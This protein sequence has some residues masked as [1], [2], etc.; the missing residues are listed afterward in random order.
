MPLLLLLSLPF[1]VALLLTILPLRGRVLP[2][3]LAA[4]APLLGLSLLLL[5]WPALVN[6]ETLQLHLP[7]LPAAG[8]HFDLRLDGL[9]A[10]FVLLVYGIGLL[11]VLYGRYYL[12]HE[13]DTRRFFASLLLFM[14]AMLGVAL[15]DNLL[16][17]LTFWELTSISSFLLIG[18]WGQRQDS[19]QGA[20]MAL[21]VTGGG[22]LCLLAGFLLLG[23][24]AGSFAIPEVI[25]ARELVQAD[26]RYPALLC[27]ILL[28]AF[29]KSA[30]FP[31]H[32]WLP[33]A[34]AA[35]TPVS[36][37]LHSATMVKAGV[38]LLA[39]LFP[40][41]AGTDLWF[42]MVVPV[43]LATLLVGAWQ[44]NLQ[45]DL[46]GLLAY[47]TISHLGL[48]TLLF[49]IG[50]PAAAVAA[51]FHLI[52]HATFKAGLFMTAGIVDHETGTRDLSKLGGLARLMP[53]TALL[54]CVAAAAMAGVPLLNGFLSKEM[55][56]GQ[57]LASAPLGVIWLLPLLAWLG[58]ALSVAYSLRF[59]HGVFFGRTSGELPLT[60]HEAPRW[61]R[62]PIE[63]LVLLCLAVG[64]FPGW[65]VLELLQVASRSVVGTELP[66]IDLALWHGV[67]LPL[68]MSL[69]AMLLGLALYR[70]P[71]KLAWPMGRLVPQ[72]GGKRLFDTLLALLLSLSRVIS[73]RWHGDNLRRGLL[74]WLL[75]CL[76]AG[77]WPWWQSSAV[78]SWSIM[79]F[80]RGDSALLAGAVMMAGAALACVY[81]HTQRVL[82]VIAAGVVG[83]M[84]ALAFVLYSSPDLALTQLVVEV[85]ATIL[86]LLALRH[87]PAP[88]HGLR[89]SRGRRWRDALLALLAGGG[90]S[91]LLYF[92]LTHPVDSLSAY[93]LQHSLPLGGGSNVVNVILV[94]FRGFDTFGEITV[95]GLAGLL[96]IKLLQD[97]SGSRGEAPT[98]PMLQLGVRLLLPF[99][100]L[101]AAYLFLRGHQQPGGGFVAGLVT[102]VALVL[103]VLAGMRLNRLSPPRWMALGLTLA[104]LTGCGAWWFDS[105]FLSSAHGH[106]QLPLLGELE[107]ATAALFDLAVYILVVG[108]GWALFTR[109][110]QFHPKDAA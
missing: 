24:I 38:F 91:L 51:L 67:N 76:L 93:Y 58:T 109:L 21:V 17:L 73:Q 19:R 70:W 72:E 50:T 85:V 52:N 105:E 107:W 95:L 61:M 63:L 60:P 69:G 28:G 45:R 82:A 86:L 20:R 104:L 56:Y 46:K 9:A 10:L 59:A 47:S 13:H 22:G 2:P 88:K 36:A 39:R 99:G 18:Y 101:V 29:A 66:P 108:A 102:V 62:V 89:E 27:L 8:I 87:L 44:A 96:L 79:P 7:W 41:L 12:S 23:D 84:T 80:K 25:A 100:L 53:Y 16:L 15:A 106:L 54:G 90:I 37:Y 40:L 5:L 31:L 81:W 34:M 11:V 103:P 6:D 33:K 35:P 43:G 55:F 42:D 78:L 14:G 75:L 49:G 65:T 74:Y 83:L 71:G 64:I 98:A 26:A 97:V 92:V 68:L 1:I 32:F 110:A 30:Q 77:A 48:I 94:D 3:W 4:A 57:T